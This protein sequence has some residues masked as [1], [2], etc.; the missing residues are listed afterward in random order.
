MLIGE[1]ALATG[2][3]RQTIRFYE[4]KGLLPEASRG[5]NGYRVYDDSTLA[6]LRFVNLAQAA[7]MTLSEIHRIIELREEGIVPCAHVVTLIDNKLVDVRARIRHL[8]SPGRTRRTTP[9][10]PPARPRGLRRR[11]HLPH[12]HLT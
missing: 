6:R 5:P 3:S 7:G 10:Q 1:L 12:T 11:R 9:T 8:A 2:M 4:R